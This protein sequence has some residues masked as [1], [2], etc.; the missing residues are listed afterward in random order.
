MLALVCDKHKIIVE[1]QHCTSYNIKLCKKEY[2]L[3]YYRNRIL[4]YLYSYLNNKYAHFTLDISVFILLDILNTN[5]TEVISISRL[6][7]MCPSDLIC[8][9]VNLTETPEANVYGAL[10]KVKQWLI[11]H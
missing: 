8:K 7:P 3:A 1:I 10:M 11:Y 2:A 9:T 5:K 4:K 6:R